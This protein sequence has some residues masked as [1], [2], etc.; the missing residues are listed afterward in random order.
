M[1]VERISWKEWFSKLSDPQTEVKVDLHH[2]AGYL[3]RS[4]F[5]R[6]VPS[7]QQHLFYFVISGKFKGN[8]GRT[9]Y[10]AEEGDVIWFLPHEGFTDES[11]GNRPVIVYR[12]RLKVIQNGVLLYPRIKNSLF[13][14]IPEC[15]LWFEQI[16]MEATRTGLQSEFKIRNLLGC[17]FTELFRKESEA[18]P[19]PR[20]LSIKQR[21]EISNYFVIRAAQPINPAALARHMNFSPDYFSRIFQKTYGVSPSRWMVQERIRLAAL[22]LVESKQNISEVAHEFGYK[23]VFFF[24]KQFKMIMGESPARYRLIHGDI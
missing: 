9:R 12:F 7:L 6:S 24:S 20:Q 22:R 4:D 5:K 11:I 2:S 8:I 1:N 3:R 23:D 21:Q 18:H 17:L 15:R 13:P 10:H 14:K 19:K 16:V